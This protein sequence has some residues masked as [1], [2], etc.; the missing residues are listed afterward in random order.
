MPDG[1]A[2]TPSELR[3]LLDYNPETGVLTWRVRGREWFPS[4]NSHAVWNSRWAGRPAGWLSASTGYHTV[5]V[6]RKSYSAHRVAWAIHYGSWPE[7]E[8][9][10]ADTNRLNNK[11]TNLR[12]AS[13]SQNQA[14]GKAYKNNKTGFKGVYWDPKAEVYSVQIRAN[15]RLTTVGRFRCLEEAVAAHAKAHRERFGEFSRAEVDL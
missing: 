8:V 6:L 5:M 10:H 15:R 9:D 3:Q 12:V 13:H 7:G 1:T 4:N 2:I 11:V 14:N